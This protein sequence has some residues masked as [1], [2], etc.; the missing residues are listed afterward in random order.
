VQFTCK[1]KKDRLTENWGEVR[2]D[3]TIINQDDE[4]CANYDVLTGVA[5][6]T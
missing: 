3:T 5:N 1:Q 2:W 6:A 4:V